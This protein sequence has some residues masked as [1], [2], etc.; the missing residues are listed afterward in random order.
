MGAAE[1][2]GGKTQLV[3]LP[4]RNQAD[5]PSLRLGCREGRTRAEEIMKNSMLAPAAA[6][7]CRDPAP[8]LRLS[9]INLLCKGQRPRGVCWGHY[10]TQNQQ[11]SLAVLGLPL[12]FGKKKKKSPRAS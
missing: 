6:P 2:A 9:I 8:G 7:A 3:S 12:C 5:T 4:Q 11:G 10:F 1:T